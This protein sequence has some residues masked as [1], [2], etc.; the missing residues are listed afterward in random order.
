MGL[1]AGEAAWNT[2]FNF[3]LFK[4]KGYH[5]DIICNSMLYSLGFDFYG[6]VDDGKIIFILLLCIYNKIE[7]FLVS[8]KPSYNPYLFV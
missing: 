2:N 6:G 8:F 5:E 4:D 1:L 3:S 7:N